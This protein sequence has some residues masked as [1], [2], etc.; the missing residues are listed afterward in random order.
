LNGGHLTRADLVSAMESAAT[1]DLTG[2]A[3]L[4]ELLATVN[5]ASQPPEVRAMLTELGAWLADGAARKKAAPGDAQYRHAGAVAAM[6]HLEVQLAQALFGTVLG[7]LGLGNGGL[8]LVD[9]V[10]YD[11]ALLPMVFADTPNSRGAHLGSAYDSGY[12]SYVVKALRLVRGAPVAAPFGAAL[13]SRLCGGGL[14]ACGAALAT[15][16]QQTA[17]DLA[18]ANGGSTDAAGWTVSPALANANRAAA[19]TFPAGAPQTMPQYD[20][21]AFRALGLIG[22][23]SLDWQNRPTFQQVVEFSG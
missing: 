13:S 5:P 17:S 15:A 16:L 14:P 19:A 18:A 11:Y 4:P 2:A 3:V 1:V 8:D 22:Q 12:E 20:A 21:I 10:P 6:D 23:P 7:D 9:G